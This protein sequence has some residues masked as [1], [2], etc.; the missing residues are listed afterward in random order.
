MDVIKLLRSKNR[1]LQRFLDT[2][3][4]FLAL[5]ETG[6][7]GLLETFQEAREAS[8]KALE[9]YDGKVTEAAQALTAA[10]KTQAL[11]LEI[12]AEMI[13]KSVIVR[14]ILETDQKVMAC[15]DEEK[16]RVA[17]ELTLSRRSGDAIKKFKS[18]WM[19]EAGEELDKKL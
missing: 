4:E 17:R 8:L 11:I 18:A 2:S 5:A 12:E 6:D 1:C 14:E 10:Q 13:R 9:L 16:E 19:P 3:R 15:L 7:F